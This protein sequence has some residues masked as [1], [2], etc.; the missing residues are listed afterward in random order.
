GLGEPTAAIGTITEEGFDAIM[1]L[2]VRGTLFTVQKA[3]PL[4]SDNGAIVLNCSMAS[5][6]GFAFGSVYNASKAAVRSFARSW[7]V[8]LRKRRIRVNAVSPGTIDTG[9]IDGITDKALDYFRG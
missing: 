4:F 9:A 5:R 8:D 1:G 3:L 7:S 6:K 2:N